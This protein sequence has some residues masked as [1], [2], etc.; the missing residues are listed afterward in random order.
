MG[1]QAAG[2]GILESTRTDGTDLESSDDVD[3]LADASAC[4]RN[5]YGFASCEASTYMFQ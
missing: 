5:M 3:I 4:S 1:K 2:E